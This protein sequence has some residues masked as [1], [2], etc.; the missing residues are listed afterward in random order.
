MGRRHYGRPADG[1]PL[2]PGI[3]S[4]AVWLN[5]APLG[6]YVSSHT[7]VWPTCETLHFMGLTLL[8]GMVGIF[9]LRV[10]GFLTGLPLRA[11]HKLIPLGVA[12][13]VVNLI[14]GL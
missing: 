10:L 1:V 11:V 2:M 14:T 7:W 4:I 8:I 3:D 12:G 6:D 13:F 9:D 5:S